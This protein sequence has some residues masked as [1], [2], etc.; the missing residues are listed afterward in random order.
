ML[1]DRLVV[2][3]LVDDEAELDVELLDGRHESAGHRVIAVKDDARVDVHKRH[4]VCLPVVREEDADAMVE[5]EF[6][7]FHGVQY[8]YLRD[9]AVD[10]LLR[11]LRPFLAGREVRIARAFRRFG[12]RGGGYGNWRGGID[13]DVADWSSKRRVD[14][15][16]RHVYP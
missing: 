5:I 15:E 12:R 16:I 3:L 9:F 10:R 8:G 6:D 7:S 11:A 14:G 4:M 13:A 1:E 2:A